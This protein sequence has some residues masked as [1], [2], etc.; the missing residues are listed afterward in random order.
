MILMRNTT[1]N[2]IKRSLSGFL[3][4]LTLVGLLA[5]LSMLPV[6]AAPATGGS[7][8]KDTLSF[9]EKT[10]NY[11]TDPS[12]SDADFTTE[13]K[14]VKAMGDVYYQNDNFE[15]YIDKITGEVAIKDKHTGDIMFSNPYD[16]AEYPIVGGSYNARKVIDKN[17]KQKLLSQ[18]HIYYVDNGN[19]KEYNS[20][21]DAALLQQ[22]RLKRLNGGVRVEYSIGEEESRTLV[23]RVI[24]KVRFEEFLLPNLAVNLEGGETS[25]IYERVKVWFLLQDPEAPG[26]VPSVKDQ[27]YSDY[28]ITKKMPVYVFD[29]T[30]KKREI[31]QVEAWI[32]AYCPKYTYEELDKDHKETEYKEKNIA[33]ANFKMALEYYLTEN[34]VEV[35]FPANGLTFDES[36]YQLT[37]MEIL[38]YM[39]AGSSTYNGY[40]LIPDGSGSLTRF[41][42]STKY[43]TQSG[44]VYGQDYA[45]QQVSNQNQQIFRMPVFGVVTSDTVQVGASTGIEELKSRSTGYIAIVTEGDAL[46]TITSVH[47]GNVYPFSS[48]YCSF[49]PRP[50]DSYNLA[51]AITITNK[52]A[53]YTVVSKR[54]YTGSFRINYIMLTDE[55][56]VN[57]PAN[58]EAIAQGRANGRG[59]YDATYVGMAKAYREFLENK[60]DLKRITE[61]KNDIPLFIEV[62][63]VTET[64]ET[65]LSIP[66]TVKK[67]LTSFDDLKLMIDE[68]TTHKAPITNLNFRLKGYINGGL[69]PTVPTKV[70][71]EKV[72][73][74]NKGFRDFL[75]YAQ[76]M[77]IE[78]YPEFDFAYME[79]TGMFDGFSYRKHAVKTIDNRY[80]TKR[81]YDAVLQTFTTTGKI[82]ISPSVYRDFFASFNKS[83]LKVLDG[84]TTNISVGSLGS[85]L[86]SDFDEDD[87]YN[88]ED[89]KGFTE[90]LLGQV[91]AY[92]KVMI[93][94]GNAY[95][96]PYASVILNAPLDSS[97]FLSASESVPF[98][99]LVYHGYV[100]IAGTPT[101]MAGDIKYEMLKIIE[102][103]ATVYMMVSYQNTALLKEDKNLSKYYAISYEIWKESLL[104]QY[105]EDGNVVSVGLYDKI[106]NALADVQ[107]STIIDHR[108]ITC[109]RQLTADEK[110][111]IRIDSIAE[112]EET[113]AEFEKEYKHAV[114]RLNDY[115]RI[116]ATYGENAKMYL[117]LYGLDKEELEFNRDNN[118]AQME[119]LENGGLERIIAKRELLMKPTLV[120]DDGSVVYVEYENGHWFVLN[121]NN[122]VVEAEVNG[123]K[124]TI[125]AK[126]FYDSKAN[127]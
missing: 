111:N 77:G 117:E 100:V 87:P 55:D 79:Q 48:V 74:G 1:A 28:P 39:G 51:E 29:T 31:K 67:A 56:F 46:T 104:T 27:M 35:R 43:T 26:I 23:P 109:N 83:M 30:A 123:I 116:V 84:K 36:N 80:V 99:G 37:S 6:L 7:D 5:S 96:V 82:C 50:K 18:V 11:Y 86:N 127:A 73:G 57:D 122:Y 58:A 75:D 21:K 45:Y 14:R 19:T 52:N 76:S 98:F 94:G 97:R 106:N 47:G 8:T 22:I 124:L 17:T 72:I 93:D 90:E 103:G 3:A 92:G 115:E 89:S 15:L 54:K 107:T 120:I 44:K 2:I 101:N 126:E 60:G 95:A 25:S 16:L 13:E 53:V 78:V 34:G 113:Y 38:Q 108:F 91:G 62:F 102:N 40:T 59:F 85:D 71:F 20:F 64:I 110:E 121:Y 65:K 81:A 69:V 24:S 41:E 119:Y 68:L 9:S 4:L 33:P 88:R 61:A 10:N 125:A 12:K 112:Y 66:V 63:G 105:D 70:K 118:K 114:A 49:N 32:K 42:D